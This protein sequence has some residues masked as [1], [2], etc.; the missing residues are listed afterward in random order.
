M[1]SRKDIARLSHEDF[2]SAM[3]ERI[4]SLSEKTAAIVNDM[5]ELDQF[6]YAILLDRTH[7]E[8]DALADDMTTM[9]DNLRSDINAYTPQERERLALRSLYLDLLMS[10]IAVRDSTKKQ[11]AG[12]GARLPDEFQV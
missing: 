3:R 5:K 2:E 8:D 7:K 9:I 12:W 4:V 11:L 1:I 10:Q 6:H